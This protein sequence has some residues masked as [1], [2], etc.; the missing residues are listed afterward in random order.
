MAQHPILH[1]HIHTHTPLDVRYAPNATYSSEHRCVL[2]S[3][4]CWL[5]PPLTSN[6]DRGS[7]G[8]LHQVRPADFVE[9]LLDGL[10]QLQGGRQ[11][12]I[13]AVVDL[14]LKADGPVGAALPV[15]VGGGGGGGGVAGGQNWGNVARGAA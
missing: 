4:E 9:L 3:R 10:E 13:G 5:T 6:L 15:V 7:R 11:P 1:N 2:A 14:W 8:H 12:G